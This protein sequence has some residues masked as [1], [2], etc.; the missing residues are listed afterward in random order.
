MS[1]AALLALAG[2]TY[3]MKALGPMLLGDRS[4]P[5]AVTTGLSLLAVPLFAA[6]VLVQTFTTANAFVVDERAPAVAVAI[7]AVRC[8]APFVIVVVLAALTSAALHALA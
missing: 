1:W 3:V 8:H 4:L 6:L 2:G 7:I 5:Q